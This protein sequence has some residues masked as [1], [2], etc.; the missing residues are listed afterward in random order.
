[1]SQVINSPIASTPVA[2]PSTH[3]IGQRPKA[4]VRMIVGFMVLVACIYALPLV[5]A[6]ALQH[7][8]LYAE[9]PDDSFYETRVITLLRGDSLGNPYLPEHAK[10]ARYMPE[11]VERVFAWI[12]LTTHAALLP[13]IAVTRV[14]FPVLIC[15]LAYGLARRLELEPLTALLT[16]CC[17]VFA[18]SLSLGGYTLRYF[19][20]ISPA[21]YIVMVMAT[22]LLI[23]RVWRK[24]GWYSAWLAGGTVGLLFYTPVYYW[25]FVLLGLGLLA[26]LSP[27]RTRLALLT[28]A[29][30][31]LL[32]GTP[33]LLHSARL[34]GDPA[35]G[36]TLARLGLMVSGRTPETGVLPR[37]LIGLV[38]VG[39]AFWFRAK[40]FRW[41]AFVLPFAVAGSFM[42]V[43][44][45]VTNRHF[46]AYHMI[47]CLMP[48][49]A[50]V[51][52]GSFQ[53]CRLQRA[54]SCA[55]IAV[56]IVLGAAGQISGYGEWLRNSKKTPAQ[57]A[58]DS[59]FPRTL[60]WLNS[61]TPAQSV[62]V[63]PESMASA[64]PLFSRNGVYVG[65]HIAQYVMTNREFNSRREA[66]ESWSPGKELPYR[67][68]YVLL[69]GKSCRQWQ[70]EAVFRDPGED[71]CIFLPHF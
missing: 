48:L 16:G 22:L 69:L 57:Y 17:T 65:H 5:A 60:A 33:S 64:A 3:N 11:L 20:V 49:A 45:V 37:L 15:L 40:R 1:M 25:S 19:R 50:L 53:A 36:E 68:D 43:Q 14:L 39:L 67:A 12:I 13:F 18:P 38:L 59:A 61:Q 26:L 44:N 7:K 29:A 71:T 34:S 58:L 62:V 41:A 31:A 56:V 51:I 2:L 27:G 63:F 8:L 55:A 24:A 9:T 54:W 30:L 28:S 35:V 47:S 70:S 46:Q 4:E 52:G 10:V 21:A 66:R 6:Y 42:L 32:L 23:E